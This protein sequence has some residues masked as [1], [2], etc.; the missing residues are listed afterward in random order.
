MWGDQQTEFLK[1]K[2]LSVEWLR[3]SFDNFKVIKFYSSLKDYTIFLDFF[4]I[5]SLISEL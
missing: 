3:I 5:Y 2:S 1:W 4:S